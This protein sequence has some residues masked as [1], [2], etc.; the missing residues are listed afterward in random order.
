MWS[1]VAA[2]EIGLITRPETRKRI[3]PTLKTLPTLENHEPSGMF[4]NWYDPETGEKLT[5]W[6]VNGDPVH[7]F[8]SSVDNGWLGAGA[9]GRHRPGARRCAEQAR[10]G[11]GPDG[12]RL[13]LQ[14][15]RETSSAAASG[16]TTRP[17]RRRRCRATTA[18]ATTSGYTGHHYGAFNTEPRMASY[19]GIAT[20]ADPAGALLRHL[21]HVPGQTCDW[22]W[23]EQRPV[24]RDT[25]LP[26]A[27][28]SSRAPT[29]T[30][31]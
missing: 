29:S 26:R 17:A 22:G 18:A 2:R 10:R 21:A 3:A 19:L 9:R 8:L 13:L 11:A 20:R 7:P 24:G 6:P 4:Y 12:L 30:A 14:P 23:T 16:R 28:R 25:D 5:T 31:A 1:A 15:G 27:S